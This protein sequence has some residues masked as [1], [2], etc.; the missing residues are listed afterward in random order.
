MDP[1]NLTAEVVAEYIARGHAFPK[2]AQ[3]MDSGNMAGVQAFTATQ[4]L[5]GQ[6]LGPNLRIN[7]PEDLQDYIMR[8]LNSPD[9]KGFV[10]PSSGKIHMLNQAD[11][12]QLIISPIDRYDF[13]TIHRYADSAASYERHLREA[14]ARTPSGQPFVTIDNSAEAG[15]AMAQVERLIER[16]KANPA[17]LGAILHNDPGVATSRLT[18]PSSNPG[19]AP[20][21][22]YPN[23]RGLEQGRSAVYDDFAR[24]LDMVEHARPALT[25]GRGAVLGIN[26]AVDESSKQFGR[27]NHM[28]FLDEA[29]HSVTEIKDGVLTVHRFDHLPAED[30]GRM[31]EQFFDRM[32]LG[33]TVHEG[34]VAGMVRS[35]QA[36]PEV[37]MPGGATQTIKSPSGMTRASDVFTS[38]REGGIAADAVRGFENLDDAARVLL[39]MDAVQGDFFNR[40]PDSIPAEDLLKIKDPDAVAAL[41]ELSA[42]KREID[43]AETGQGTMEWLDLFKE[44]VD[45]MPPATR[46]AV[47]EAL[48]DIGKAPISEAADAARMT[49]R[50]ADLLDTLSDMAKLIKSAKLSRLA[51]NTSKAGVVTTVVTTGLSVGATAFANEA[52]LSIAEQLHA[53]GHLTDEAYTEY[54]AMMSE[55]APML[56]GQAADPTPLAIPGM[57]IVEN[58]A[59]T[60]FQK[61]SDKHQLPQNIH[62]ML[63][64]AM[65]P[66]RSMRASLSSGV[67][68]GLPEDPSEVNPLL[69]DLVVA[70]NEVRAA[71]AEYIRVY[72]EVAHPAQAAGVPPLL[73]LALEALTAPDPM[74]TAE[75]PEMVML[76]SD[77]AIRQLGETHAILSNPRVVAADQAEKDAIAKFAAEFDRLLSDPQ[78]A[79]ALANELDPQQLLDIVKA[80]AQFQDR[81]ELDPLVIDYLD[82]EEAYNNTEFY[83]LIDQWNTSSAMGTAEEALRQN[84]QVMREYLSSIFVWKGPPEGL[85]LEDRCFGISNVEQDPNY[86][87]V[88]EAME[89]LKSGGSLY[90]TE[91]ADVR[92]FV[93]NLVAGEEHILDALK[94]NYPDQIAEFIDEDT[95]EIVPA[96]YAPDPRFGAYPIP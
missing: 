68:T 25:S 47:T 43:A 55:V 12:T 70:H 4:N 50:G 82:A 7:N 5:D 9:T 69:H 28:A 85:G 1:N 81:S 34:G 39:A 91:E 26:T 84:P 11:N 77:H 60:R 22:K 80:S 74:A 73:D 87:K 3:G 8:M 45:G 6:K 41:Q 29:T 48:S 56:T 37:V 18:V 49:T 88:A 75:S 71:G 33:A 19:E 35:I 20:V 44:Q 67:S 21:P 16:A 62:E 15:A 17:I 10:D 66:G 54:Q 24:R 65:I 38:I 40:I 89:R 63:T 46:A 58:I 90:R 30:A 14:R 42:I 95:P 59:M 78:G 13:G 86:I 36:T 52:T 2:H 72:D 61:F 57:V 31:A 64:P 96:A 27:A 23:N 93:N 51:F 92:R 79:E 53:S 83:A 76:Q 32:R 94:E